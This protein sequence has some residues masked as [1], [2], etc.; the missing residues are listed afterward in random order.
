[1]RVPLRAAAALVLLLGFFVLVLA[2]TVGLAA[3]AVWLFA[4]GHGPAG[5]KVGFAAAAVA[6]AVGA[7]VRKVLKVTN[8][9]YGAQLTRAEYPVLWRTVDELAVAADTRG[10]D[11]IRLVPE[12]NA[13]VWEDSRLLGLKSG[14]RYLMIGLPLLAGLNVAELRAVLAHELGHYS[15]G[16]TALSA[17]T[18]RATAALEQTTAELGSGPVRWV[19]SGYSR[20]YAMVAGASNRAQELQADA[21]SV[22]AAGKAATASALRRLPV[23]SAAWE[24][25]SEDYVSLAPAAGRTPELLVGFR[26][27]LGDEHR[28]RRIAEVQDK[29]IDAEPSSVFD[30]HPPV[31]VRV[32]ALEKLPHVPPMTD[33]RPAWVLL[34]DEAAVTRLEQ[35]LLV[36]GLG[37][38]AGW[39]EITELAG[40]RHVTGN[41]GVLAKTAVDGGFAASGALGELL[42]AVRRGQGEQL[43]NPLVNP[44]VPPGERPTALRHTLIQLLGDTAL[45]L[46]VRHG[47][48]RFELDWGG[49]WRVRGADGA[50]L[51]VHERIEE[52]LAAGDHDGLRDWLTGL[53]VPLD[54]AVEQV[55]FELRTEVLGLFTSVK[56]GDGRF[57]LFVCDNGLL[58]VPA[59][60][61]GAMSRGLDNALGRA[62]KQDVE[63]VEALLEV[64]FSELRERP[65]TRWIGIEEIV[66]GKLGPRPWGWTVDLR[67]VGGTELSVRSTTE[68]TDHGEPYEGIGALLAHRAQVAAQSG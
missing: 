42:D 59:E 15:H 17:L 55:E 10:P 58:L 47:R 53:G 32:A 48:A 36:D 30:S 61:A 16:H 57:D 28:A 34:G 67:L 37:P 60:R 39:A 50:E 62:G 54:E 45:A 12:V 66:G 25:Y 4:G 23:L 38:R 27:F 2:L 14:K 43:V 56:S 21:A 7:A 9:P 13:A 52:L 19:L 29:L 18:Y 63:R 68:T 51:S 35:E 65:D 1:M 8:E 40:A 6:I 46:L 20:L 44:A 3:F 5:I 26:A 49:P 41:A 24:G 64:D 22:T 11:D 31:R 33:D